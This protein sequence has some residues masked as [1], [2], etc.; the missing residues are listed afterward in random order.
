[1]AH[2]QIG[3]RKYQGCTKIKIKS[4]CSLQSKFSEHLGYVRNQQISKATGEHF[5][6]KGHQISDMEISIIEKL[7][8]TSYL[9]RK[10]REKMFIQKFNTK[11]KGMNQ[12]T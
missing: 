4:I 9:F 5:N 1:M 12:K 11:Y 7:H 8:N 10:Q 3:S 2:K 6:M